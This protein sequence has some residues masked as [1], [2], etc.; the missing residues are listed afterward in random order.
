[1][2]TYAKIRKVEKRKKIVVKEEKEFHLSKD[3][4]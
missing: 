3:L 4:I 2:T 1:M